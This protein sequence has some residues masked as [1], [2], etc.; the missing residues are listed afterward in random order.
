M[1]YLGRGKITNEASS[2]MF[3]DVTRKGANP[4]VVKYATYLL[5]VWSS[6]LSGD[7]KTSFQNIR[8]RRECG[9]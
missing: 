9:L 1:R 8:E 4:E 5:A 2:R 3:T 6:D 7:N